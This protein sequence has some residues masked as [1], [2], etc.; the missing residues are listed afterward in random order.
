MA[1]FKCAVCKEEYEV[2]GELPELSDDVVIVCDECN[3]KL[4]SMFG[5]S[6]IE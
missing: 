2:E 4:T 5:G 6:S 1:E 3:D